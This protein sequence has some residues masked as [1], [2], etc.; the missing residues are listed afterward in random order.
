MLPPFLCSD[1]HADYHSFKGFCI[2]N[3]VVV[4]ACKGHQA[5][6]AIIIYDDDVHEGDGTIKAVQEAINLGL[7]D[8]DDILILDTSR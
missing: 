7:L 1:H 5:G 2:N 6:F 8:R 3:A 4:A